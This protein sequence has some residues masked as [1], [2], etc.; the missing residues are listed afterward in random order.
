MHV[1]ERLDT[2]SLVEKL[3]LDELSQSA[4]YACSIAYTQFPL[5]FDRQRRSIVFL[6]FTAGLYQ[7]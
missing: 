5:A 4:A 3:D 7:C 1:E 2:S 6:R